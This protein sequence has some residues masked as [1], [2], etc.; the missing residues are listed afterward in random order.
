MT[1]AWTTFWDIPN[2]RIV[3]IGNRTENDRHWSFVKRDAALSRSGHYD[4]WCT[5]TG[6]VVVI[7]VRLDEDNN[8][9]AFPNQL[10]P[11]EVLGSQTLWPRRDMGSFVWWSG[12]GD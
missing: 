6:T 7:E 1:R 5:E 9:L 8:P 3:L 2:R 11:E 12:Q 10:V 4:V